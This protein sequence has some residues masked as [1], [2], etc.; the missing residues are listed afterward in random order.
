[1]WYAGSPI[2]YY[3]FGH[4]VF[5]LLT[6]ISGLSSAITYNLSIATVCALTFVSTFSLSGNLVFHFLNTKK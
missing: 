5:A 4:L 2:N 3:Y 6:K 1:M